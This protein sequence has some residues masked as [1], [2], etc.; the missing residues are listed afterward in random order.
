ME[1]QKKSNTKQTLRYYWQEMRQRSL[2]LFVVLAC[3]ISAASVGI[4][5]PIYYKKFF[6]VLTDAG[7]GTGTK[8]LVSILI[9]IGLL[10]L[11]RWALWRVALFVNAPFQTGVLAALSMRC[12][13]YLHKHSFTYFNNNFVGSLVKRVNWFTRA[14]EGMIDKIFWNILP[15]LVNIG[16]IIVVLITKNT[17]LAL[18]VIVWTVLFLAVNW[19][20]TAYKIKFDIERNEAESKSTAVLADTITNNSNVK[21]FVGYERESETF[22]KTVDVVRKLRNFTWNL[23]NIFDALQGILVLILQI[24]IFYLAIRLWERGVFTVGD[25]VLLQTYL[26]IIFESVWGFGKIIRQLY[27][28][29]AD[30]DEMTRILETPHEIQDS[31]QAGELNVTEGKIVFENVDFNYHETRKIFEKLNLTIKP[32]EKIALVG[33]SGAGKSTIVKLLLRMHDITG[34]KITIDGEK[35]SS[36][37]QESLWKNISLVPQDPILFHRTLLENIRYGKPEATDEE[38]VK[39]AKKAHCH[40]FISSFP[41]KYNTYVGERGVK[42]SGGE[43]QR[44]AIARAILRD[45]PILVLDEATSSLDS[46]SESLIQDALG[47]LMRNKTVIV[48]AHRLSTIMKMDR[49][50]V[51]EQGSVA[52]EGT[53]SELLAKPQ[54]LYKQLWKLQAGGFM[55]DKPAKNAEEDE[56]KFEPDEKKVDEVEEV[57]E[58]AVQPHVQKITTEP[59]LV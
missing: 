4:A 1:K 53:H 39:A 49:I 50:V 33:P 26:I 43:R 48:I 41:D 40:E 25:F 12:F 46:E 24:G 19:V 27:A 9:I 44:V 11:T 36:V 54:G 17:L 7:V 57:S 10:E 37:T 22:H 58:V 59:P 18:A 31:A 38:V 47:T 13:R 3:I 15:L 21:L 51:V 14:F 56:R 32:K 34:G 20:F 55:Q 52:E 42:L 35:I 6:D 45:A 29:L 5:I 30:A 16:A 28:D 8:T 23:D 2:A